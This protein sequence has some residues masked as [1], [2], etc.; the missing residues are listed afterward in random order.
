MNHINA[1]DGT[2]AKRALAEKVAE[3]CIERLMPRMKTLDICIMLSDDM[4]NAD[5]FCLAESK[6]EFVLEIDSKLR[7]DDFITAICHEMIHVKQYARNELPLDGKLAYKTIED[8]LN[9]WY[10]VEA[11]RMQEEL[12]IQYKESRRSTVG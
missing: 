11:Y 10:E 1:Y 12:L 2:K 7:G 6:R 9:A 3:F 8:Y 4:E 5:G